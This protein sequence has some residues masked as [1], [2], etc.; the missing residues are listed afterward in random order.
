M[1]EQDPYCERLKMFKLLW[2]AHLPR[3]LRLSLQARQATHRM[4]QQRPRS[5]ESYMKRPLR[6]MSSQL[7]PV[8]ARCSPCFLFSPL[9]CAC[10]A[11]RHHKACLSI[12][13]N[14]LQRFSPKLTHFRDCSKS[15]TTGLPQRS[16]LKACPWYERHTKCSRVCRLRQKL[17]LSVRGILCLS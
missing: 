3:T 7:S 5:R 9:L 10:I 14:F 17:T 1:Y 11:L 4:Y 15:R 16:D 13:S 2:F 12:T 6:V 8:T